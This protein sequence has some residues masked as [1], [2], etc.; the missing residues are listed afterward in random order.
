MFCLAFLCPFPCSSLSEPFWRIVLVPE[1]PKGDL[2]RDSN[3]SS[4]GSHV[5]FCRT[6]KNGGP[7][8]RGNIV[9]EIPNAFRKFI[10]NPFQ[11]DWRFG[12]GFSTIF[13]HQ[14]TTQTKILA[15]FLVPQ[16]QPSESWNSIQKIMLPVQFCLFSIKSIPTIPKDFRWGCQ[17]AAESIS[18][19]RVYIFLHGWKHSTRMFFF[20]QLKWWQPFAMYFA[21]R[22]KTE[23]L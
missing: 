4:F 7:P 1:A 10:A 16:M 13:N 19:A 11:D 15:V 8:P 22:L 12:F 9:F 3:R 5:Q 14:K 6:F 23:L 2:K 18:E 17:D 21:I 20:L